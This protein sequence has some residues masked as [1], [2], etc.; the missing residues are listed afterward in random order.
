[1]SVRTKVFFIYALVIL[2]FSPAVFAADSAIPDGISI[3]ESV[4]R[5]VVMIGDRVKFTI[6]IEYR[7][8]IDIS[9]PE[10]NDE[11]VGGFEIKDS[12]Y[13][14]KKVPL[15][16]SFMMKRW[17]YLASFSVGKR[18]IPQ[19]EFK[20]KNAKSGSG[21]WKSA[22][23]RALNITI[24]SSLPEGKLPADIKDV[25][26]PLSYFE[27][28]WFIVGGLIFIIIAIAGAIFYKLRPK[29]APARLPHELAL[30]ELEA[31]RRSFLK[32]SDVKEYY[33]GIS[34]CIRRYIERSFNLRAPEMTTEEFLVSLGGSRA[35]SPDQKELLKG[36]LNACDLVK[37][38]KYAPQKGEMESVYQ[39]AK[40]FIEETRRAADV[41]I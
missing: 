29:P 17:Y 1:M 6:E 4:D 14:V 20:Y 41:H 2:I 34:D 8:G 25:K 5:A 38:A 16:D 9:F 30:E 10:L 36:F 18:Q 13:E 19:I 21:E 24:K 27:I 31:I 37:F 33:A 28:N 39:A 12:G 11:K 23:T 32:S 35:L 15:S 7:R 40:K 26:R 3:D 22:H